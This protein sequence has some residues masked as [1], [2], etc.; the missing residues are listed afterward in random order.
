MR[1]ALYPLA[2][3]LLGWTLLALPHAASGGLI[4][5]DSGHVG[6]PGNIQK[7]VT[8]AFEPVRIASVVGSET[9]GVH[10]S[11]A[12]PTE[13]T[14]PLDDWVLSAPDVSTPPSSGINPRHQAAGPA[15][16]SHVTSG[17]GSFASQTADGRGAWEL[18]T[19]AIILLGVNGILFASWHT[20]STGIWSSDLLSVGRTRGMT[21][22]SQRRHDS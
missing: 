17:G 7:P 21:G 19:L 2:G 1:R 20:V 11:R 15:R 22:V 6:G 18:G 8:V 12:H 14:V 4:A 13:R 10:E 5:L 16:D 9:H 3:L